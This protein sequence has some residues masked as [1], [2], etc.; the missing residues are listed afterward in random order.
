[1][2][3]E[4][5]IEGVIYPLP[6]KF[7]MNIFKKDKRIFVK[8]LTHEPTKKT[9]MLLKKG[10]KLFI[11]I[12]KSNKAIYGEAIIDEIYFMGVS[13][14]LSKFKSKLFMSESELRKYSEGRESKKA[15]V[16]KIRKIVLYPKEK[17]V[18]KPITMTG[19]Y[20]TKLNKKSIFGFQ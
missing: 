5:E 18:K 4:S 14:I 3:E 6:Y 20:V 12:S 15:Q 1:M 19:M 17:I 16:L 11:Y 7:A 9:A 13:E 8:Y 2:N 10:M